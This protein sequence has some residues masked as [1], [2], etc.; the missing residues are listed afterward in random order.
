MILGTGNVGKHL[1]TEAEEINTYL[2]RD[3]GVVWEEVMEG[4]TIYDFG[5]FGGLI[6]L[7][8]NRVPTKKL[9][10]SWNSGLTWDFVTLPMKVCAQLWFF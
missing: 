5:D 9:Y 1:E 10:F 7:A 2:S 6:V 8:L 4:S 3:G